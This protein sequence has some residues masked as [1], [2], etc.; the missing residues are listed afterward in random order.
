MVRIKKSDQAVP[1]DLALERAK[2]GGRRFIANKS[3]MKK[4][5]PLDGQRYMNMNG[6]LRT[7]KISDRFTEVAGIRAIYPASCNTKR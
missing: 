3:T 5:R 7:I 1:F 2:R 4:L 6:K